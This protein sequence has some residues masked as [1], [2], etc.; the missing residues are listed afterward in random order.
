[1]AGQFDAFQ[2]GAF[3]VGAFQFAAGL[4]ITPRGFDET[5]QAF[6]IQRRREIEEKE[7]IRLLDIEAELII[8]AVKPFIQ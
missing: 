6:A 7:V 4:P 3:Q 2:A 8:R 5:L 1:M